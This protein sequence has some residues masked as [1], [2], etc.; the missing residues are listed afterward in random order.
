MNYLI[1][2][3]AGGTDISAHDSADKTGGI[4]AG[5]SW[6]AYSLLNH[7]KLYS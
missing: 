5:K 6:Y 2:A 3:T 1:D 4:F 7:H